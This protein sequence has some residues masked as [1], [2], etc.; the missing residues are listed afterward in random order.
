VLQID[1]GC[2]SVLQCVAVYCSVLQG[3]S[4]HFHSTS[5]YVALDLCEGVS[6]HVK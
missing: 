2:C 1:A 4:A 5:L 6:V 3:V